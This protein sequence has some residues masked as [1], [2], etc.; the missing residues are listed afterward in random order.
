MFALSLWTQLIFFLG[1]FIKASTRLN[2]DVHI[3]CTPYRDFTGACCSNQAFDVT[4][5]AQPLIFAI[6]SNT[7]DQLKS[8]T[9]SYQKTRNAEL[10]K[11]SFNEA[12]GNAEKRGFPT[13]W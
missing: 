3:F 9:S 4:Y 13:H 5:L 8:A 6:N 2:S 7:T 12:K 11:T 1:G 10:S